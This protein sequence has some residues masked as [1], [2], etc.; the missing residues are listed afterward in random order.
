MMHRTTA[1][2]V[3]CRGFTAF[4]HNEGVHEHTVK[5]NFMNPSSWASK[6]KKKPNSGNTTL[7]PMMMLRLKMSICF[8]TFA[9]QRQKKHWSWGNV[10]KTFQQR[11][12]HALKWGHGF[13]LKLDAW[14]S[15]VKRS[16]VVFRFFHLAFGSMLLWGRSGTVCFSV[17]FLF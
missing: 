3:L 14:R 9:L 5:N 17:T 15:V 8:D 10:R 12:C 16:R 7:A 4:S 11:G 6:E 2:T 13:F 1:D